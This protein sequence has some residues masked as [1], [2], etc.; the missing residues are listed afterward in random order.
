[1]SH[2]EL[3][4]NFYK[5]KKF[6]VKLCKKNSKIAAQQAAI[7]AGLSGKGSHIG[8]CRAMK[9]KFAPKRKSSKKHRK[10]GSKS[11]S[12][13]PKKHRKHGSKSRS[14]SPKKHRKHGSKSRSKSPKKHRKHGSKSRKSKS[15]RRRS[16]RRKIRSPSPASY[17]PS[18][19]RLNRA[20]Q[21]GLFP[22]GVIRV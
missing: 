1:M 19:R 20:R 8:L 18:P 17:R 12:K 6:L 9:M 21:Y 10:H 22:P 5:D 2:Q 16:P 3:Y 15:P 14:R 7:A 11:R 13:S 4:S